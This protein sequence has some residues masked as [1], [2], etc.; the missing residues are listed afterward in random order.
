M[1]LWNLWTEGVHCI[2]PSC[3][4][5]LASLARTHF[6]HVQHDAW[7]EAKR[8]LLD[9]AAKEAKKLPDGTGLMM[10]LEEAVAV[11]EIWFA[12]SNADSYHAD[13]ILLA[14]LGFPHLSKSWCESLSTKIS[15]ASF[16]LLPGLLLHLD[17][18]DAP[19]A[20]RSQAEAE[21]LRRLGTTGRSGPLQRMPAMTVVAMFK[22]LA[23]I[24]GRRLQS[25][26]LAQERKRHG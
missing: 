3:Q 20:V 24:H 15:E 7:D 25:P 8:K 23:K 17:A 11:H 18:A 22:A 6:E 2:T 14:I 19:D 26:N 1:S 21:L 9:R 4:L 16:S 12:A 13:D 5:A 10:V